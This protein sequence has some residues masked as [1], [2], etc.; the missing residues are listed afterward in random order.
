MDPVLPQKITG[1][2]RI[3]VAPL[4]WG[5]GHATRCIP[6]V[7]ELLR[8]GAEV[9]LA[10]ER[11]QE[12]LLRNEF[13]QLPF[14]LLEGYRISYSKNGQGFF[15]KMLG[16]VGHIRRSI[17][18]ENIWLKNVI[19]S[20][21]FDAVLSDNRYGLH[22]PSVHSVIITHQLRIRTGLGNWSESRLQQWNYRYL[23]NFN[24]CWVPDM[25]KNGLAGELSHPSRL[26]SI[27]VSYIGL[28]SR[29][30][31]RNE[32]TERS[33]LLVLASGPEPQRSIF[34]EKVLQDLAHYNGPAV[35]VRGLPG[36]NTIIPSTNTIRIYNHLDAASLEK[37]M[38][39]AEL[40]IARSGYSTI[41]DA[42]TMRKKTVLVPTP[43][44]TEQEYLAAYLAEKKMAATIAQKKFSLKNALET[45]A[46]FDYQIPRYQNDDLTEPVS[47]LLKTIREPQ[48]ALG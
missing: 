32:Q 1:K 5:L 25:E 47:R 48:T 21:G 28:L 45:A 26:P 17:K 13:P 31:Y 19:E 44:Q 42:L 33:K 14:L 46:G 29:F 12:N 35:M 9:W 16:Q 18:K 43:G 4:D 10:G 39:T 11:A 8:Q 27:P 36:N 38:A 23:A 40:L 37:E 7:R 34:E 2:L 20:H 30:Q 22:H 41:M 15:W 24:E 3:L 6:L